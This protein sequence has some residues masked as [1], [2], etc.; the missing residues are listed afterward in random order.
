MRST[1]L[2][3]AIEE[4]ETTLRCPTTRTPYPGLRDHSAAAF[5]EFGVGYLPGHL[6]IEILAVDERRVLCRAAVKKDI[7]APHGFLHGGALVAIGDTAC[8]YGTIAN[9]PANATGFVTVEL[10]TNF[11]GTARGG[12][13]VLC[14]ATAVHVGKNTHVWDAVLSDEESQRRLAIFRCTQMV[15]WERK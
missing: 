15:L 2:S 10:K 7:M 1:L 5:N 11:L 13:A 6:G 4:L 9:L 14:A 3:A 12:G 8:G